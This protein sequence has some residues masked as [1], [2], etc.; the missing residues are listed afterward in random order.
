VTW[1]LLILVVI[2][3][4]IWGWRHAKT[5]SAFFTA[6]RRAGPILVGLGGTAAGLSAFIFVGGPGLFAAIGAASLWIILSAPLTGAMQCWAVGEPIVAMVRRHGCITIP[7]LLAVRYGEGWPRGLAAAAVTV[8]GIATLAVQIRGVATIGEVL[9][10]AQGWLVAGVTVLVVV[11][12]S[13]AGGMRAGLP[14]EALQGLIMA[15]AAIGLAAAALG[16][17]GGATTAVSILRSQRPDLLDPWGSVGTT[18]ALAWFLLFALGT[19]AQPHY[20]QKFLML[21]RQSSLR[22][23]PLVMTVALVSVLTVWLGVGLGGTALWL[24]GDIELAR[25]DQLAPA[26]L[27]STAGTG[28][29]A[30]ALVAVIAAVMSTAASLLNLV[31]AAVIRDL[32]QAFG[33]QVP[34]GLTSARLVTVAAGAAAALLALA[35]ERPVAMLGVLGWGTFTAALL[36]AVL[37]GLNWTGASRTGAITAM[38]VGPV[39]QLTMESARLAGV[40][41]Q[42]WEPGLTGACAGTLL[43]VVLS[44]KR[45]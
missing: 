7:D 13:A 3:F 28:L 44:L 2:P 14:A 26:L 22:W 42:G 37:L 30:V 6:S 27:A 45:C 1:T 12:Y 41:L 17:A 15:A 25:P 36:P 34:Q 43:L 35:S 16:A 40:A 23:L 21:K 33:W 29:T 10:G 5:A 9:T 11:A 31:A 20:L 19:C 39:I 38:I 18:T 32:P 4:V 8:G 24:R